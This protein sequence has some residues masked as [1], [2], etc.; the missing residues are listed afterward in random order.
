MGE[1]LYHI[2]EKWVNLFSCLRRERCSRRKRERPL[3]GCPGQ[4]CSRSGREL[5]SCVD[6]L[7]MLQIAGIVLLFHHCN[8][9][10][11]LI[12]EVRV[13]GLCFNKVLILGV[14]PI[15]F[16]GLQCHGGEEVDVN[17]GGGG[18]KV[19]PL[20]HDIVHHKNLHQGATHVLCPCKP[21]QH[22]SY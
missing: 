3:M 15:C 20:L 11:E 8:L 2:D 21:L 19:V 7:L 18:E 5:L 17:L 16:V 4:A 12:G 13:E 22:L 14:K 6:V 10:N 1:R 9:P